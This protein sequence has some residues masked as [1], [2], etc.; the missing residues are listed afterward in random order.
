MYGQTRPI[1]SPGAA[2]KLIPLRA[3]MSLTATFR[4]T[5]HISDAASQPRVPRVKVEH[6]FR[7]EDRY[8]CAVHLV[9]KHRPLCSQLEH[10]HIR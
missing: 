5:Q 1:S 7:D 9:A 6:A 8:S 3:W 4:Q 10:M 2:D